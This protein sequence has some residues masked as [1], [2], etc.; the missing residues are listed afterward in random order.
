[1]ATNLVSTIMQ[2]FSPD[3]TGKV[4]SVLGLDQAA[5]Q[6][7]I[8][9]AIPGILASL[10]NAVSGSDGAQKLASAMSRIEEMAGQSGDI[11][12]NLLESHKSVLETGW[13]A[14]SSLLGSNTLETL[15]S[16]VAQFA[17][18]GR[19]SAKKL[20]GFLVPV[21][22]GYLRREQSASGL[23]NKGLVSLLQSQRSNIERAMPAGVARMIDLETPPFM[24]TAEP[25]RAY[26]ESSAMR[27]QLRWVYWVLPAVI[28]AGAALYFLSNGNETQTAEG[29]NPASNKAAARG[30]IASPAPVGA[31]QAAGLQSDILTAIARLQV[32]LQKIKD[33]AS[34]QAAAG[35]LKDISR[36]FARLKSIAQQLTA[37][38]RKAVAAS[39]SAR[40]PDLNSLIDR[41]GSKVTLSGEAKPAMDTVKTELA[42]LSKA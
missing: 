12:N 29:V 17:G 19:G 38:E 27:S 24:R 16:A 26:G 20:L 40:A 5:A 42:N 15:V 31:S 22:L 41:I 7:G 28:A 2:S 34:A 1:M 4:A 9:A 35:E 25:A 39:V 21:V 18:L 37:D 32:A 8:T 13:T 30:P 3:V 23:D 10:A 33:T 36:Q 11:A 6:K 14:I